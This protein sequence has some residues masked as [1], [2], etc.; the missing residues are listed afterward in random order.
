MTDPITP[1]YTTLLL[2]VFPVAVAFLVDYLY[3]LWDRV[4]PPKMKYRK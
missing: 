4:F 1:I 2:M 3:T